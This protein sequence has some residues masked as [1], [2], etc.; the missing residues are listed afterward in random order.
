M[1]ALVLTSLSG[2][3]ALA[4]QN[5]PE[6]TA[7]AGQT[8]VRVR[9][10]VRNFADLMTTR[11]GSPGTPAPPLVVGR[12][13]AGVEISG[14]GESS[15]RRVMGYAQ[16]AAFAEKTAAYSNMIWTIPDQWTDEQA[17][18]KSTRLNSSHSGIW[19]LILFWPFSYLLSGRGIRAGGGVRRE[20]CRVL[21]HDLDDSRSMDR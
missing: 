4:I 11:G 3:D 8:L 2:P 14:V 5:V 16:W 18:R 7:K 10:G 1:K 9:S 17:D 6:P 12:E 19:F 21:Q 13:F 20:D 15:G